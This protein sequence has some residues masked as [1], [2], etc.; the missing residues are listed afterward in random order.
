M[1]HKQLKYFL[2]LADTL[3]FSR[4]SER[5]YISPPTLSRQ[6]K[7]LEEEVGAPLFIRDNRSVAL[8]SQ[9][10]AFI[11]YAQATLASW[12]QFKSE[13][14]DE[15]KPLSGELSL[16]CSVTASY[17]FI[18]DLFARYRQDFPQVEL[19]LLTG[20]PANSIAQVQGE[21]VDV[22]VAVRPRNLPQGLEY[23]SI[24]RSRLL[25]IAPTMKC[26]L[27]ELLEQQRGELPW[28]QV[29]FIVP[30]HGVL[31]ERL[32]VFFKKKALQPK[33]YAHVSGHEAMV[34]L[35]SLG[36]GIAYVPEVVL[37]QSPFRNQVQTLGLQ[38]EE[39]EIGL[40]CKKK[41]LQ[42]PVVSA[43]FRVAARLFAA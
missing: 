23:L 34:A 42:D 5:C 33:I 43:L 18:Y 29:P 14:L 37:E 19:N 39:I 11:H 27:S 10:Q 22:A 31:K 35:T 36:F 25:F 32:D 7:Q 20:D 2:A 12:R 41:R 30:E 17:S 6:I 38:S 16:F 15:D 24:G 3:H 21:V 1:D 4:A 40:V 26:P 28:Q 9:G 8:T 13:C